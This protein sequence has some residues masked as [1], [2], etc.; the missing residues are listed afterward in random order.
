MWRMDGGALASPLRLLALPLRAAG[1]LLALARD[2]AEVPVRLAQIAETMAAVPEIERRLTR[3]EGAI[4]AVAPLPEDL[5]RSLADMPETARQLE[6]AV[7]R[8]LTLLDEAVGSTARI[9]GEETPVDPDLEPAQTAAER[10]GSL[11]GRLRVR[12]RRFA[13]AAG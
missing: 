3:I 1:S 11:A 2:L 12:R 4:A 13:R 7:G 8:L 6:A 5:Q 10:V 9:D